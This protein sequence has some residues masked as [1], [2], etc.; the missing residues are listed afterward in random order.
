MEYRVFVAAFMGASLGVALAY[1]P[2]DRI[3]DF[4]KKSVSNALNPPQR[5][6]ES[7]LVKKC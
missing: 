5:Q 3:Y 2:A 4:L 1:K 7:L 6:K